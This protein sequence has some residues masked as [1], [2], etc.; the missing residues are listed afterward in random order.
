MN[1]LGNVGGDPGVNARILTREL[2]CDGL[3]LDQALGGTYLSSLSSDYA[4]PVS[5]AL[6]A[7]NASTDRITDR[8]E[9][10]EQQAELWRWCKERLTAGE[11]ERSGRSPYD[12]SE[13]A[14]RYLE[15]KGS[16]M[17]QEFLEGAMKNNSQEQINHLVETSELLLLSTIRETGTEDLM[18]IF[19]DSVDPT[20]LSPHCEELRWLLSGQVLVTN[21]G[22]GV[23]ERIRKGSIHRVGTPLGQG[24]SES[25]MLRVEVFR[26]KKDLDES[27]AFYLESCLIQLGIKIVEIGRVMNK[28][29]YG[30]LTGSM[31][32]NHGVAI[33]VV[34]GG[35][36]HLRSGHL[37]INAN[38]GWSAL[39]M[40]GAN[41]PPLMGSSRL[42][43]ARVEKNRTDK[44]KKQ[45]YIISTSPA[46]Q[47][48]DGILTVVTNLKSQGSVEDRS[49]RLQEIISSN[50]VKCLD[51]VCDLLGS[52][53]RL[54]VEGIGS[55]QRVMT[56]TFKGKEVPIF[57]IPYDPNHN[58]GSEVLPGYV[59]PGCYELMSFLASLR[60]IIGARRKRPRSELEVS[61]PIH[62]NAV[63]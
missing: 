25:E 2:N 44:W 46:P 5:P 28:R 47:S 56:I 13:L 10:E 31:E 16:T 15:R 51:S 42:C 29:P 26:V 11:Q 60:G 33:A 41:L 24:V 40:F 45:A 55:C 63:L 20:G 7:I 3:P 6:E 54:T 9:T 35:I 19:K 32:S 30:S 61:G 18:Y 49:K 8:C 37:A 4:P 1:F 38:Q 22:N 58:Y 34:R 36:S 14:R 12:P 27:T 57:I 17:T 62:L 59:N 23:G 21:R 43:F 39:T 50:G 53:A 48:R 52:G